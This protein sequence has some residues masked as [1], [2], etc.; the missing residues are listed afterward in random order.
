MLATP[1]R[2]SILPNRVREMDIAES[3]SAAR[4]DRAWDNSGR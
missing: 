3:A 1:P 4:R 2:I